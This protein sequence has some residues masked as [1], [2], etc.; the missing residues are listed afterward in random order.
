MPQIRPFRA[1]RPHRDKAHLVGSRS[2]LNYS[3]DELNDKLS[4]NPF[5]FLHIIKPEMAAS[6]RKKVSRH[7]RYHLVREGY[8]YYRTMNILLKEE[9]ESFYIYRQS[10]EGYT[11][12][13]LIAGIHVDEYLSGHIKKH[14]ETI[15]KREKLFE[16]YLEITGFNAEP[17]LLTYEDRDDINSLVDLVLS[18]RPEFE[19]YTTDMVKHEMW[20]LSDES[21][22]DRLVTAMAQVEDVYIADGHHRSASSALLAQI[23]GIDKEGPHA[24]FMCMLLPSSQLRIRNFNRLVRDLNGLTPQEF[25]EAM[26]SEFHIEAKD[27]VFEPSKHG[28]FSIYLDNSWYAARL[29]ETPQSNQTV[30][31][32]D[33]RILTTKILQPILGISDLRK[34]KRID[35]IPGT[36][37][38]S[39]LIKEVDSGKFELGFGLFPVDFEQLK[40]VSDEGGIMPP[41]STYIEPKLR[42]GL[43]IYE[44]FDNS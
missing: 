4:G 32:L 36:E 15:E 11:Y 37:G 19:F 26:S 25:I 43:T 40:A 10:S 7:D 28:E 5:T 22:E 34:D 38:L 2:Y 9:K 23:H 27:D 30:D 29:K 16:E 20:V 3:E 31:I 33:S 39:R 17:V 6:M 24:S 44:L 8:N 14:E 41:K 35:F 18:S 1:V 13:G 21:L 12:T 42:S